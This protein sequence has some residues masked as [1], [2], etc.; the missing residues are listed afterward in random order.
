MIP[1]IYKQYFR[2]DPAAWSVKSRGNRLLSKNIDFQINGHF[3]SIQPKYFC[4]NDTVNS[5]QHIRKYET[6]FKILDEGLIATYPTEKV[7]RYFKSQFKKVVQPQLIEQTFPQSQQKIYD[8]VE[9]S[10]KNEKIS[11]LMMV[12]V[13]AIDENDVER[14]IKFF[15]DDFVKTGYYLT[16]Y[17]INR[18]ENVLLVYIQLEAK[19]TNMLV[20]LADVLYH[21][22]P[23]KNL[24]KILRNGLVPYSK[25]SQF[26]YD[27]RV[28]LFNKCQKQLVYEYAQYKLNQT[29]ESG[30]CL[31]KVLKNKLLN[32]PLFKDGKQK[33]Y[34]DPA[35]SMNEDGTDQ[36]A[37]FTRGN[38][39]LRI[40]CENYIIVK[41]DNSGNIESEETKQL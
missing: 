19:Y 37:I 29:K 36:T 11:P 30:F 15:T 2:K 12:C 26:K 41:I 9:L 6:K 17:D 31:F 5:I 8:F 4:I 21:V 25:S 1:D 32:D 18:C 3:S 33:F 23:L 7:L 10:D 14:L 39:P 28:Y 38:I 24:P 16:A 35:F 34:L 40:L 22:S 20:D 27:D 13:P